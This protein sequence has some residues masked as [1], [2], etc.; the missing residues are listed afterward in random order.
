MEKN[1]ESLKLSPFYFSKTSN[2][3][4]NTKKDW[5][6]TLQKTYDQFRYLHG[7]KNTF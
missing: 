5:D 7:H 1:L 6:N 4:T 2:Y 3:K